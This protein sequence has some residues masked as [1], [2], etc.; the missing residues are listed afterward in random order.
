MRS[1]DDDARPADPMELLCAVLRSGEDTIRGAA[2]GRM[3]DVQ[4]LI[5]AG[6][7]VEQGTVSSV[8]CDACDE[9]H[10]ASINRHPVT[11]KLVW[12]CP[13]V[14]YVEVE[15]DDIRAFRVELS[16][17]IARL[18]AAFAVPRRN[19][20]EIIRGRLWRI[21]PARTY[22]RL[23]DVWFMRHPPLVAT[24]AE[25]SD[26]LTLSLQSDVGLLLHAGG[27]GASTDALLEKF[28]VLSL[29]ELV[30]I[31]SDGRLSVDPD[32]LDR[33]IE[34]ALPDPVPNG[35]GRPSGIEDTRTV[36]NWL[37]ERGYLPDGRNA[38]AKAVRENWSSVFPRKS[39]PAQS[40]INSHV[41]A[42]RRQR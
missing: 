11:G 8:H 26:R 4:P 28:L 18:S 35:P 2:F 16:T 40:T 30:A 5:A 19:H 29:D 41:T 10:M 33:A 7:L 22:T 6:I 23:A 1:A 38:A 36:L 31:D 25:F 24:V 15:A 17:F 32:A 3:Q 13:E 27:A 20:S 34:I 39:P 9:G 12:R 37:G 42:L 21:G 14:S